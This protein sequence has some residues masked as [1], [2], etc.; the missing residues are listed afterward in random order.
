MIIQSLSGLAQ[1]VEDE[2]H[3]L[4][5][6]CPLTGAVTKV[7]E[8]TGEFSVESNPTLQFPPS[9]IACEIRTVELCQLRPAVCLCYPFHAV[10]LLKISELRK[11]FTKKITS[12]TFFLSDEWKGCF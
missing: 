9:S 3:L 7:L 2:A 12:K 10:K 11:N 5:R 6:E 4:G 1:I 8:F